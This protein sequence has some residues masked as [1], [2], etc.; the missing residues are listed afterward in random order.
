[1][2]SGSNQYIKFDWRCFICQEKTEQDRSERD[3]WQ[4][5][6]DAGVNAEG[7]ALVLWDI[8]FAPSAVRK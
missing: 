3:L 8:V 2:P 4:E 5:K 6:P 1:M 7:S